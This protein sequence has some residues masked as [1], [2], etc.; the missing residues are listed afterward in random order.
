AEAGVNV[1]WGGSGARG[2]ERAS[3]PGSRKPRSVDILGN[4]PRPTAGARATVPA[5]RPPII[6]S[7]NSRLGGAGRLH[8]PARIKAGR[9]KIVYLNPVG[10]LG[11]AERSLLDMMASV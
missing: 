10:A 3:Q 8:D 4:E 1:R 7:A 2:G 5:R 9:M 11:G 6:R